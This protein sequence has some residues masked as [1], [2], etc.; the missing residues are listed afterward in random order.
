MKLVIKERQLIS[1]ATIDG[2]SIDSYHVAEVI[3]NGKQLN[4][5][6][7]DSSYR[8]KLNDKLTLLIYDD[9]LGSEVVEVSTKAIKNDDKAVSPILNQELFTVMPGT[10]GV[11]ITATYEQWESAENVGIGAV[12]ISLPDGY[13]AS[14]IPTGFKSEDAEGDVY[15]YVVIY[16][17]ENAVFNTFMWVQNSPK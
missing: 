15:V 8:F 17:S 5:K 11:T 6:I 9:D 13:S 14:C 1:Q 4:G 16:N 10:G 12:G 3:I 7:E 2:Q